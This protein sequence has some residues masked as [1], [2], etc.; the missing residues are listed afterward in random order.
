MNAFNPVAMLAERTCGP[1][2]NAIDTGNNTLAVRHADKILQSQPDL[3]LASALKALALVRSGRHDDASAVCTQLITR[4][5]RKGEDNALTPLTWT[6][7]RLGRTQDEITLLEAAVKNNPHDQDLARQTFFALIKGQAFQKAQ[8]LALKM[9]KSFSA[10]KQNKGR[11][12]DEYFWW[13]ILAYL[14]LARDPKAPGA[15]LALPLSQRMIE[16]QIETKPLGLNDEEA[17]CLLLQVLIR[18]GKKKDAFDLVA[19]EGSVGHTLCDRNLSLEFTRTDLARELE[20]WKYVEESCRARIDSGSRNWVHFTGYLDAAEKLGKDHLVAAQKKINVLLSIK[21]ATKD[22]SVRLAELEVVRKR[23]ASGDQEADAQLNAKVLSYFDQFASKACCHE[24]LL[25]YVRVLSAESKASLA[26]QLKEKV[27][28]LPI[29][30]ELDLRTNISIAKI[31]RTVQ[32]AS[33]L[34]E[35]SEAALSASLL[36]QYIDGLSV[37]ASLPDTEMQPADDLALLGAQALLSAYRLSGGKLAYLYQTIALLEFALTKSKKGYQ[38][39][40]LL[41][42]AYT[43]AG[44]FDRASIHYGLIGLKSVQAD[45]LSHLISERCSS[46]SAIPSTSTKVDDGLYKMVVRTLS[47]S[48]AIYDENATS[49]PD[50]I[51]KALEHGIY[52]RVEEFVEFGEALERS[53]QRQVLRLEEARSHLHNRQNFK[54]EG[55]RASFEAGIEKAVTAV[56][57]DLAVGTSDQ[58][59]FEVL[60]NF[61]PL[62]TPSV[63]ELTQVGPRVDAGWVRSIASTLSSPLAGSEESAS[64]ADLKNLTAAE[65][66]LVQLVS[67]ARSGPVDVQALVALLE[68][69]KASVRTL[70]D[71]ETANH[72]VR[73]VDVVHESGVSLEAVYHL[74][75]YLDDETRATCKTH[76]AEIATL[77]NHLSRSPPTVAGASVLEEGL[78]TLGKD[79]VEQMMQ[80]TRDNVARS[81]SKVFGNLR[82]A[83]RD[84]L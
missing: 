39:R 10:R 30:N 42:R 5:L 78:A 69:T 48:Q 66:A 45:T 35:E 28:P 56:K 33:T 46:F 29:K 83:L 20:D 72:T 50:M 4:G 1:I 27:R 70:V 24:D 44:A 52:S 82:D 74:H 17:L 2:Y 62:G 75:S 18:Q 77:V 26:D 34:T 32:S 76:L 80:T 73:A 55:T 3:A 84:A 51:S 71:A 36:Q 58:R 61:Q 60:V 22:R 16:K 47:T 40:M 11:F 65:R 53:L 63:E 37:G 64:E 23:L 57:K 7:G 15:A 54:D 81:W 49:T 8:Q 68:S 9:H 43:L 12:A 41:I 25:P 67:G 13:S 38:L 21:G 14:L 59:D 31:S 19:A 79:R 6:L